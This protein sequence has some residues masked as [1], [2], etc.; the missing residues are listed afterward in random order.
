MS[1]GKLIF[2]AALM[3]FAASPALAQESRLFSGHWFFWIDEIARGERFETMTGDLVVRPGSIVSYKQTGGIYFEA[4][5]EVIKDFG[6]RLVVKMKTVYS[7]KSS[8]EI[9]EIQ[10]MDLG[11]DNQ[12]TW[13]SFDG[14][15]LIFLALYSCPSDKGEAFAT[16]VL[17]AGSPEEVWRRILVAPL[18]ENSHWGECRMTEDGEWYERNFS[19]RHFGRFHSLEEQ[20]LIDSDRVKYFPHWKSFQNEK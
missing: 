2:A 4:K 14:R 15:P 10:T 20:R 17:A 5:Y 1:S 16:H 9:I 12:V 8:R 3:C 18:E 13:P 19:S 11:P 6:D 7:D